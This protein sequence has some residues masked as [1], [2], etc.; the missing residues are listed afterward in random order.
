MLVRLGRKDPPVLRAR[1]V[2]KARRVRVVFHGKGR[3]TLGRPTR[4]TTWCTRVGRRIA[5]CKTRISGTTRRAAPRT[6]RRWRSRAKWVRRDLRARKDC[7]VTLVQPARRVRKVCR[8]KWA[9][10]VHRVFKARRVQPVRRVRKVCRAKWAQRV[11]RVFKARRVQ[12]VRRVRR[13]RKVCKA[14]W[15]QRDLRARKDCRVTP[16]QPARRVLRAW[17]VCRGKVRMTLA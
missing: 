10:R 12:P 1:R 11:H 6:G 9:Q 13:V 5:A 14:K 15:V 7:R 4:P 3:T 8:A 2:R 17:R 16:V